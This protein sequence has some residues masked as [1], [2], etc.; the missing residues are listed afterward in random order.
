MGRK[1]LADLGITGAR[2]STFVTIQASQTFKFSDV[3]GK[4]GASQFRGRLLNAPT[5]AGEMRD[6]TQSGSRLREVSIEIDNADGLVSILDEELQGAPITVSI[7]N[8]PETWT[9]R[10]DSLDQ[11]LKTGALSL[12]ASEDTSAVLQLLWP[13]FMVMTNEFENVSAEA[14]NEIIPVV[15]GG[16]H[17]N[18]IRV[19]GIVADVLNFVY[20]FAVGKN[21]FVN[22]V[23][24]DGTTIT[25]GFD[26]YL[27]DSVQ[28][29]FPGFLCV[30]F[31]ADP[32]DDAGR[33]PEV[34]VEMIG[35]DFGV[36]TEA[37][38]N[39]MRIL[40]GLL[41]QSS[42][43]VGGW[44]LGINPS[45]I[46]ETAFAQAI[47]DCDTYGFK[48]DGVFHEQ[49]AW[50]VWQTMIL[51]GCRGVSAFKNGLWSPCIDKPGSMA[52]HYHGA[53]S[54]P[55][56][57]N[58]RSR[59]ERTNRVICQ[60]R[61]RYNQ[62]GGRFTGT[63]ERNNPTEIEK[64]LVER[65]IELPLVSDHAT[66]G[67]IADY[68][69]KKAMYQG[70]VMTIQPFEAGAAY[71]GTVV[72]LNY[73]E[74]GIVNQKF[75]VEKPSVSDEQ[76]TLEV[77]SY[78]DAIFDVTP[79]GAVPSDPVMSQILPGTRH[80]LKPGA[81]SGVILT[82][83]AEKRTDGT[84]H[85]SINGSFT[86]GRNF[87]GAQIEFSQQIEAVWSDWVFHSSTTSPRF[88]IQPVNPGKTYKFR[89]TANGLSGQ[90]APVITSEIT[91]AG[92]TGPADVTGLSVVQDE[93]DLKKVLFT[94]NP[95]NDLALK[96]Y[97]IRKGE[98]WNL[99]PIIGYQV[100]G[101]KFDTFE[102]TNGTYTYL[103]K[104]VDRSNR[105]SENPAVFVINLR[106]FPSNVTN[107]Q[108]SQN[109]ENIL[110]TWSPVPD[111]DVIG[112]EI[113]EGASWET[114]QVI[115][116]CWTD[117]SVQIEA[118][119][120]RKYIYHIKAKT[121]RKYYSEIA[122]TSAITVSNLLPRNYI[123]TRDEIANPSGTHFQTEIGTPFWVFDN[124]PLSFDDYP[125]LMFDDFPRDN[126]LKLAKTGVSV[127]QSYDEFA[128]P[129][130]TH[131]GTEFGATNFTF[132]GTTGRFDDYPMGFDDFPSG[133]VLKLSQTD[134]KYS[135]NGTYTVQYNFAALTGAQ[136]TVDWAKFAKP[137]SGLAV[138]EFSTSNDGISWTAWEIFNPCTKAFKSVRFRLTLSTS[139][140]SQTPEV[141]GLSVD[142]APPAINPYFT[143][144]YYVVRYDLEAVITCDVAVDK[145]LFVLPPGVSADLQF[146]Y[147]VDDVTWSNWEPFSGCRKTFRYLEFKMILA[148]ED[149]SKTPEVTRFSVKI[150]VPDDDQKGTEIVPVEGLT[151]SFP[152]PYK[153]K[154]ALVVTAE[155]TDVK[156]DYGSVTKDGFWVQNFKRTDGSPI[157]GQT[158]NWISKGY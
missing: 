36:D 96:Y 140:L 8:F 68:E 66:A 128:T 11:D 67:A 74:L 43:G 137:D 22:L 50:D 29:V 58:R 139:D 27:G 49:K 9:G 100:P 64:G 138:L 115:K 132:D 18:Y 4:K 89:I 113:R 90:A 142:F 3:P 154:P 28:G 55:L 144:G 93:L 17:G 73:P 6:A 130:G 107:F 110:L 119:F 77:K 102:V 101:P 20:I 112:Y 150:D 15:V 81:I 53:N 38:R 14:A 7:D 35:L 134:G 52:A 79:I 42:E 131:S 45:A 54:Y 69:L 135:L 13:R 44:G 84:L 65:K 46:D 57:M 86:P 62:Q 37:A 157:G 75:R 146:R 118:A 48:L 99:S 59:K 95:V 152:R 91:A 78:S 124:M 88:C 72:N 39:P 155:G 30:K 34:I 87:I 145:F 61:Y 121:K 156:A 148:T 41:T 98:N 32:R 19:P 125:H 104:A 120:E 21:R 40:K 127:T 71:P 106:I 80:I 108:A 2:V 105:Y 16:S 23:E 143:T 10:I 117:I 70:L 83:E 76:I 26:I 153:L 109:G 85:V 24:Q 141:T 129:S 12:T 92:S 33:W 94:W 60:Y 116:D 31:H 51:D 151:I 103:V 126:V 133:T 158:I 25:S 122:A 136:I 147:S 56:K 63:C 97:E 123:S 111:L 82:T 1:S 5:I 47:A 114:G 149:S